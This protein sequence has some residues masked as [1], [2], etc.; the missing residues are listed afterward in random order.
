VGNFELI[1]KLGL[2]PWHMPVAAIDHTLAG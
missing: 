2:K 1:N